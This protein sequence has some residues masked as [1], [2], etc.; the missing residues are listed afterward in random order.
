MLNYPLQNVS[1]D[2]FEASSPSLTQAG[3]TTNLMNSPTGVSA[4]GNE[5]YDNFPA[6]NFADRFEN[7]LN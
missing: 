5:S 7:F 1:S 6:T 2:L 4:I 3:Q